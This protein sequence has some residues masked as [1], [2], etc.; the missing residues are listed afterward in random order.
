MREYNA[1][2]RMQFGN[3]VFPILTIEFKKLTSYMLSLSMLYFP[4]PGTSFAKIVIYIFSNHSH[5][6]S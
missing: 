1:L 5:Q 3:E 6:I 4:G 2:C